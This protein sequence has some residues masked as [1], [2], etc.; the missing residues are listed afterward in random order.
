MINYLTLGRQSFVGHPI[1]R[2]SQVCG[3]CSRYC[4]TMSDQEWT[5]TLLLY[6]NSVAHTPRAVDPRMTLLEYLRS[7]GT[8]V[9]TLGDCDGAAG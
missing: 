9:R 8:R 5:G 1:A 4:A 2:T 6:I 7:A 3:G